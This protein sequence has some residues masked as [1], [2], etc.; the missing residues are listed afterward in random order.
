MSTIRDVTEILTDD[1]V[2]PEAWS[3]KVIQ[4]NDC[5]SYVVANART[6]EALI[7][8]PMKESRDQIHALLEEFKAHRFLAVIDTHTHADHISYAS[9]L[10]KRLNVSLIQ[11]ASCPSTRVHL[12]VGC[13]T[14]LS[15]AAGSVRLIVTLGHTHDSICVL[16]GPFLLTG[17]TLLYGNT[18]RADL[19]GGDPIAHWYSLDKLKSLATPNLIVLP[20][21]DGTGRASSWQTQLATCSALQQDLET[22]VKDGGACIGPPPRRLKESLYENFK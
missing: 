13:D 8:D 22:F 14:I 9:E 5:M 18:G 2:I 16:W 15:A 17:D 7:V 20:G 3:A 6:G 12:R 4:N 21:H 11:Y 19:P 1:G 10:A